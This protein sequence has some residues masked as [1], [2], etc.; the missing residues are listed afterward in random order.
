MLFVMLRS[1]MFI[2]ILAR[3][4]AAQTM[5]LGNGVVVSTHI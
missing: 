1:C 4:G 2:Q 3:A 5:S